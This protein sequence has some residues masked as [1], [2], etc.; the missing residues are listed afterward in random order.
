MALELTAERKQRLAALVGR[1]P[2]KA[3]ACL[4]ALHVVQEEHGAI[5]AD[6]VEYVARLLEIPTGRVEEVASFYTMYKRKASGRYHI[7]ICTNLTCSLMGAEH[8]RE[9]LA[10][11]LGIQPGQTTRDGMFT[12]SEVEC[13]ASCGT[14][15]VLQVNG[16]FHEGLTP[17]RVKALVGELRTRA[18]GG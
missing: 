17:D 6:A 3:A 1:Y 11:E 2:N 14:A 5:D 8:L 16:E 18:A 9:V 12:L 13:L 4:P 15:P 7:E 10:R